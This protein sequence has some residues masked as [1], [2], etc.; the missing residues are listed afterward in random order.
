MVTPAPMI[1]M[2]KDKAK[3]FPLK[4]TTAPSFSA[5]WLGG[6]GLR[7]AA[8]RSLLQPLVGRD[9][10]SRGLGA[11]SKQQPQEAHSSQY[12]GVFCNLAPYFL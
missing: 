5:L 11:C 3:A 12:K 1:R 2:V 4:G 6:E 9:N 10:D 7:K 8:R